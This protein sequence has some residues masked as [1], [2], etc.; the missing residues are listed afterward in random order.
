MIE[1]ERYRWNFNRKWVPSRMK[2]STIRLPAT[3]DGEPD[4]EYADRFIKSLPLSAAVL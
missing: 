4:W 2:E 1:A 3:S